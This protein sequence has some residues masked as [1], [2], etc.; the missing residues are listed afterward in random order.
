MHHHTDIYSLTRKQRPQHPTYGTL[1][2][3]ISDRP[4]IAEENEGG[5][6]SRD[7]SK[8]KGVDPE[9]MNDNTNE[10][11]IGPPS[12]EH[13]KPDSEARKCGMPYCRVHFWLLERRHHCRRCGDIFC[14]RHC[15][16]YFPLDQHAQPHPRGQLSRVCDRC[17]LD[18]Q[19]DDKPTS[20]VD[21]EL[22]IN[23]RKLDEEENGM[24]A[25]G[26]RKSPEPKNIN[27]N[28]YMVDPHVNPTPSV[29]LDWSWSTF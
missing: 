26:E 13:W 6:G 15:K 17:Y 12:R 23:E 19:A 8:L 10:E 27:V 5:E 16:K 7:S 1:N 18:L 2:A 9:A 11:I 25:E 21:S 29:P 24:V 28:R 22:N 14:S 4:V 20:L 3:N